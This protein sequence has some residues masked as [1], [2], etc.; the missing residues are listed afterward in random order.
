M[1]DNPRSVSGERLGVVENYVAAIV[2]GNGQVFSVELYQDARTPAGVAQLQT[3]ALPAAP[4][5]ARASTATG[6]S[7][8]VLGFDVEFAITNVNLAVPDLDA[9]L[10]QIVLVYSASNRSGPGG[11]GDCNL[12]ECLYAAPAPLKLV[13]AYS[14]GPVMPGGWVT[15][16]GSVRN[17]NEVALAQ[18]TVVNDWPAPN[19][20]VL[21]PITLAAGETRTFTNRYLVPPDYTNGSITGTLT[22]QDDVG[23][24]APMLT[25]A[26]ATC[27]V[28][29]RPCFTGLRPLGTGAMELTFAGP[30]AA[31]YVV[32]A[33]TDVTQPLAEWMELGATTPIGGGLYQFIDVDATQQPSRFYQLRCP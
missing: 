11:S 6:G 22:A 26:S 7:G 16:T 23:H 21:G 12:M 24:E 8:A 19:T 14:P 32:L 33:T 30:N 28:I 27:A 29:A 15:F 2:F 4:F 5:G 25:T 31:S 13:Q 1:T 18:V 3:L 9:R 20:P 17:P 10:R